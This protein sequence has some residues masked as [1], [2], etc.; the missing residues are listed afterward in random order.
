MVEPWEP[1]DIA[2]VTHALQEQR[3]GSGGSDMVSRSLF[4]QVQRL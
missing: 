2:E 1:V 4:M 3:A